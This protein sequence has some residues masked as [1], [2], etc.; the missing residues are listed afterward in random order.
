[1]AVIY[2]VGPKAPAMDITAPRRHLSC[3]CRCYCTLILH[4]PRLRRSLRLCQ[5]RYV[6]RLLCRQRFRSQRSRAECTSP[7]PKTVN[8]ATENIRTITSRLFRTRVDANLVTLPVC[9]LKALILH[10]IL[11]VILFVFVII[12]DLCRRF[13]F[14]LFSSLLV[15]FSFVLE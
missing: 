13:L 2:A 1:M 9:T 8:K 14:R 7:T 12:F 4:R 3:F 15:L 5:Q 11:V 6:G 10:L